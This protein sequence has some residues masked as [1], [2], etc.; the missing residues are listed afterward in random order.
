[1]IKPSKVK[2]ISDELEKDF[3]SLKDDDF[4]KKAIIRAIQ[5]LKENAFCGIQIPKK[6]FPKEYVQK[7]GIKN[8][9][10]YD[11]PKGWRLLYTVTG[12]NEVELIS[13]IL[14]W[15]NHKDYERRF[16]Y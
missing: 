15:F 5:D 8:L 11:L 6:L 9:W 2:F 16:G 12:E 4:I 14:E 1:M 13:A 7:Y 3:N 10:K